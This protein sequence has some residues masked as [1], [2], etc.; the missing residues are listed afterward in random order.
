MKFRGCD[1]WKG[2][3]EMGRIFVSAN[4]G[5]IENGQT[6]PETC[7]DRPIAPQVLST[8]REL[9]VQNLRSHDYAAFAVPSNLGL[10]Q[11]I[12]WINAHAYS[13][14]IALEICAGTVADSDIRGASILYIASNESRKAQAELVLQAFL[15]RLP[16]LPSRG[17]KPD[18][19]AGLGSL[20]FCRWVN[21]PT[22]L[23]EVGYLSNPD[24]RKLLQTQHQEGALGIAEGLA[25]WS[26]SVSPTPDTPSAPSYP[27]IRINLNGAFYEDEGVLLDGNPYV[28]IDLIDQLSIELPSAPQVR[29]INY[30]NVVYVRV[31]D[32]RNHNISIRWD[33]NTRIV[34]LRSALMVCPDQIDRLMGRGNASE[35]Q[36]M[37]FLKSHNPEG[38]T[39]FPDLPKL[40]REEAILEG[41]NYDIAF[42]QMCL[43]TS[44]LRFGGTVKP[45]QNNFAGL[46]T[47]GGGAEGASFSSARLGVRGQIQHLKAYASTEPLVQSLVDPRFRFVRRGIAPK[48]DQLSGRWSAETQYGGKIKAIVQL[49]YEFADFL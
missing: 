35:V 33:N 28:S 29:R 9:I 25:A 8:I 32:L 3:E 41:V 4:Y 22:L 12:D 5:E 31:V 19:H 10:T 43:E 17:A 36:L 2:E 46:G 18:T 30:R 27:A 23:L 13:G 44:F 40:Y 42:A 37:M 15:R 7:F 34:T 26:R 24:D 45:E 38:L 49:L 20:P 6:V 1:L 21:I 39:H 48:L 16:Q 14:D 11:S 47:I